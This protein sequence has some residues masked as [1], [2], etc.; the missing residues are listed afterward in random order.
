MSEF[1]KAYK[2]SDDTKKKIG[3]SLRGN[4]RALGYKHTSESI[5]KISKSLK[6]KPAR[7]K[8]KHHTEESITKMRLSHQ[9]ISDETRRK[10][11]KSHKLFTEKQKLEIIKKLSKCLE[12]LKNNNFEITKKNLMMISGLSLSTIKR[13]WNKITQSKI[14]IS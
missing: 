5:L 8:G 12:F 11:S 3:E 1:R 7:N 14:I 4:K 9:N 6:G 10:L 2:L 13:Y